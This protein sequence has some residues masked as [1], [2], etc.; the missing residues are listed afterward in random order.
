MN[1]TH[2]LGGGDRERERGSHSTSRGRELGSPVERARALDLVVGAE[3]FQKQSCRWQRRGHP[4]GGTQ[5]LPVWASG[6]RGDG[7]HCF[8]QEGRGGSQADLRSERREESKK[9]AGA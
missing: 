7:G 3:G 2:D 9:A 8:D 1:E 6:G 5:G 4:V